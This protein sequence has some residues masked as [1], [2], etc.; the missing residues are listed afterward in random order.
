MRFT[1]PAESW[2]LPIS[3]VP[4]RSNV[5]HSVSQNGILSI[6]TN[7]L[8]RAKGV[9][10]KPLCLEGTSLPSSTKLCLILSS[11]LSGTLRK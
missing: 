8:P 10:C 2:H 3:P 6:P 1:S 9:L 11:G 5:P 7:M 4:Y